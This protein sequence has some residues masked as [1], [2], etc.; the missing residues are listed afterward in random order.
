M[1]LIVDSP[2][3]LIDDNVAE[4]KQN[5]RK[6][7]RITGKPHK[8]NGEKMKTRKEPTNYI[9]STQRVKKEKPTKR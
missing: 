7:N 5:S 6:E 9:S 8:E 1:F 4:R 2:R 3:E